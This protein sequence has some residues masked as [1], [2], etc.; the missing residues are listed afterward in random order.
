[1]ATQ[2]QQLYPAPYLEPFGEKVTDLTVA[3]LNKPIDIS[4]IAPQVAAI[5]PLTQAA[6]QRTATQAG[7]GTLTFDPTTGAATGV[8]AGTGVAAYQPYLQQAQTYAQPG[9]YEQFMSPYQ[10]EVLEATQALLNEQRAAGRAGRAAQ[11]IEAGAF[12]GG[13]EGVQRAEYERQRDLYD[14]GILANLR[15]QG[16]Q[17]AQTQQQQAVANQIN[18]MNQQAQQEAGITSQLGGTGGSISA[19]NQAILDAMRQGNVLGLDYPLQRLGQAT[20][21]ISPLIAG[22]PALQQP[23]QP[24]TQSPGLSG[25]QSLAG[26]YGVF[27]PPKSKAAGG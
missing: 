12:G 13:R 6:Q 1:M 5:S 11:A 8:G 21:I 24:F 16:L 22:S 10:T 27:Y 25:L 19:Y 17:Q 26:L 3:E 15:Q 2:S 9:S 20:N 18:F 4:T 7:L 23:T 14:A